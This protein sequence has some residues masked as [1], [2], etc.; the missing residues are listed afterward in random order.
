[1][2][3]YAEDWKCS[4]LF[5]CQGSVSIRA[6]Y[7]ALPAALMCLGLQIADEFNPGLK[8]ELG[9]HLIDKGQVWTAC[10]SVLSLLLAFRTN[11]SMSRFW[12]GTTLLH[13]MRGEW[14]DSISCL[15]T[16]SRASLANRREEVMAF[17]HLIVRLMSLCHGSALAEISNLDTDSIRT[18]DPVGLDDKTLLYLQECR[19]ALHFNRVEVILDLLQT[20]IVVNFDNGIL[21]IPAP[22]LSRVF[23]TLSRGFV[24]LLNAQKIAVTR[25]P[26]PFAHLI[27]TTLLIVTA[28]TPFYMATVVESK[29]WAPLFTFIPIFGLTS[30]N[31]IAIELEMPF[32]QDTNDLPIHLFQD[33]INDCLL[34]LLQDGA[35]LIPGI[36]RRRRLR[37]EQLHAIREYEEGRSSEKPLIF[38]KPRLSVF[39]NS[40]NNSEH[41]DGASGLAS[42]GAQVAI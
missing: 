3:E 1:M 41:G 37:F 8:D 11:T 5:R 30:L 38:K 15:V 14:F 18:I 17:R 40:L 42:D 24:N 23:Q 7:F 36:D 12:E 13:R 25:F 35:D 10:V 6:G 39:V 31:L 2:I 32:G 28:V 20:S 27:A 19:D 26:F 29:I 22:I 9:L 34:M 4:L 21:N 16:F 33:R